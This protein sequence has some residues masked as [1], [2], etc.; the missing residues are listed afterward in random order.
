VSEPQPVF[1]VAHLTK[2]YAGPPAVAANQDISLSIAAGAVWGIFGPNGAGKTTLIRQMLGLL[3]PTAG[4]VLLNGCDIGR[5][6][7][8]IAQQVGYLPQTGQALY[9]FTVQE[10]IYFTGRLRGLAHRPARGEADRLIEE[11]GLARLRERVVRRLSGGEQRLVGLVSILMG[12]PAVLMLDEPTNFMDPG[13]RR[14]VWDHLLTLNRE[15][16][17]TIVLVTHNVLEAETVVSRVAIVAGGRLLVQGAPGYLRASLGDQVHL[18]LTWREAGPANEQ[19]IAG[20]GLPARRLDACRWRI[21]TARTVADEAVQRLLMRTS[22]RNLADLRI[23]GASL[24]D[25]YLAVTGNE[26]L[27]A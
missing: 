10:A 20:L 7:A 27:L 4:Q 12:A 21:T 3:K 5:Q 18:D 11:W 22:L 15:H 23:H 6:P 16:G 25:Y 2:V 17:V 24:E 26:G 8:L 19:L 1:Q 13:L 14:L 9:D